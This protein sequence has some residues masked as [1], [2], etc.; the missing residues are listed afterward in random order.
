MKTARFFAFLA[1][2]LLSMAAICL[3]A[4]SGKSTVTVKAV[5]AGQEVNSYTLSVEGG[6][7]VTFAT[8]IAAY[9]DE[10]ESDS[11]LW[12]DSFFF[13]DEE[14]LTKY[15]EEGAT[16]DIT[17]YYGIYNPADTWRITFVYDGENYVIYRAAGATLSAQDFSRSAY[18]YGEAEDYAFYSDS[19]HT[20]SVSMGDISAE[21]LT[22]NEVTLYV[23]D[24]D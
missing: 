16:Q 19:A 21:D 17:L 2:A 12:T 20:V 10:F 1:F 13:T 9:P 15:V 23:A 18:G 6:E 8:L 22:G 5:S 4:C 24:A 3:G 11:G 14:C 7:K